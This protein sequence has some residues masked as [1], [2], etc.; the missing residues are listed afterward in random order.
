[1]DIILLWIKV[2]ILLVICHLSKPRSSFI[3]IPEIPL[4]RRE[5]RIRKLIE[6]WSQQK[7]KKKKFTFMDMDNYFKYFKIQ[8]WKKTMTQ[9]TRYILQELTIIILILLRCMW[10][11]SIKSVSKW[12]GKHITLVY[13]TFL[14][15]YLHQW[16]YER[17]Y[18]HL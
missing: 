8:N 12:T 16:I 15:V 14:H 1:M 7:K 6:K 3:S 13:W 18:L 9:K 5:D 11:T 17:L 4:L 2:W 10:M